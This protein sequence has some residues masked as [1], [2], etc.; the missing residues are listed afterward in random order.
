MYNKKTCKCLLDNKDK[1]SSNLSDITS[2]S[3]NFLTHHGKIVD[4]VFFLY[5]WHA[6]HN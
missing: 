5:L 6:Q 4:M 2:K 1:Y 3:F